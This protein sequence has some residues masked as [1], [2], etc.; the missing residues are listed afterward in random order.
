MSPLKE[1]ERTSKK[2]KRAD[3]PEVRVS[4][5]TWLS[6]M[7]TLDSLTG[8]RVGRALRAVMWVLGILLTAGIIFLAVRIIGPGGADTPE[9]AGNVLGLVLNVLTV[10]FTGVTAVQI[11]LMKDINHQEM[12]HQVFEGNQEYR[13]DARN[14]RDQLKDLA[15]DEDLTKDFNYTYV[16]ASYKDLRAFAF[17]YEYIGY[18]VFRNRLNFGIAFDTITF[19]N[20]MIT[21]D[22]A[23][24][25]IEAGRAEIPDFWN[26]ATYLYWTYEVKR[27]YNKLCLARAKRVRDKEKI[28]NCTKALREACSQWKNHYRT[29]PR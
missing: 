27:K 24:K 1:K 13:K 20:W 6:M 5:G 15:D 17:H 23:Q 21:S 8:N 26:G 3:R 10:A 18:L 16:K 11:Y 25:V 19:P 22:P 28:A 7:K 4:F 2:R 14:A 9:Q 12:S 29:L